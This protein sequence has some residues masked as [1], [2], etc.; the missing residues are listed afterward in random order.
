MCVRLWARVFARLRVRAG[1]CAR[2]A[3]QCLCVH[4]H[5]RARVGTHAFAGAGQR[6]CGLCACVRACVRVSLYACMIII[7]YYYNYMWAQC[8]RTYNFRLK[9]LL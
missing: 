6:T 7:L 3:V 2:E 8:V 1:A 9:M 5:V 4:V